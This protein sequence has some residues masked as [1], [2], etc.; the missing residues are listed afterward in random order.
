MIPDID[1]FPEVRALAAVGAA[2]A[3]G[4]GMSISTDAIRRGPAELMQT[5]AN[6]AEGRAPILQLGAGELKQMK[7]FGWKRMQGLKRFEDHLRY[8]QAFWGSDD[9]V[10]TLEGNYWNF[11][12]AWI[13]GAKATRPRVWGLG[14]G[15][16][17]LELTTTYADGFCTI[18]PSVWRTPEHAGEEIGKLRHTLEAKDRD[19][20]AFDFAIW[21][22]LVL[23]DE[24]DQESVEKVLANPLIRWIVAVFG[25]VTQSDWHID[26]M[27]PPLPDDWHYA[28]KLL[29]IRWAEQEVL[30]VVRDI[31]REMI[32]KSLLIGTPEQV[33][34]RLRAY[35][36]AG[37]TWV[38][39]LDMMPFVVTP[40]Q[41]PS[42]M[43]RSIKVCELLKR[44]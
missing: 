18:A 4:I 29:P 33:A 31:P 38:M 20:E 36:D 43:A 16:Q 32:E 42:V 9:P 37:V 15:P 10:I 40:D 22:L 28:M 23:H 3:D 44:V 24:G 26:G 27:N 14:G 7:P 2:T 35:V 1:S 34:D 19:P 12:H 25:R 21:P 41:L 39:A 5:I 13:G 6:L 11:D 30:D 8:I 17:L